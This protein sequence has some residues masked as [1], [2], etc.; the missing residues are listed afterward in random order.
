MNYKETFKETQAQIAEAKGKFYHLANEVIEKV[1][2]KLGEGGKI[3]L[4]ETPLYDGSDIIESFFVEG[5]TLYY[6][7]E[8]S[9]D[10]LQ[11]LVGSD[12]EDTIEYLI[13]WLEKD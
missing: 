2:E 13:E 12:Y 5:N 9:Y 4:Y 3:D 1:T 6:E 7:T 11:S 10:N 8:T